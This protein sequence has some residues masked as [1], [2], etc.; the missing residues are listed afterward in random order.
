V[1]ARDF[2]AVQIGGDVGK[3][4][5]HHVDGDLAFARLRVDDIGETRR[6]VLVAADC[7]FHHLAP[8][9]VVVGVGLYVNQGGGG[10]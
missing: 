8:S 10:R 6:C 7:L 5:G 4:H 9:P 1:R 3:R 2:D